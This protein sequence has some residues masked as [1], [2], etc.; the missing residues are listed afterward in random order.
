MLLELRFV[1]IGFGQAGVG[2]DAT[3]AEEA[4]I[5]VQPAKQIVAQPADQRRRAPS[6]D[7][8]DDDH[9]NVGNERQLQRRVQAVGDD[10]EIMAVLDQARQLKRRRAGVKK[11]RLARSD[12]ARG[13]DGDTALF[14]ALDLLAG[15][16]V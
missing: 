10:R 6:H 15:V 14:F 8:A 9:A 16:E 5:H 4:D 11:D 7:A 1:Q 12:Q 3:R 13:R 2:R